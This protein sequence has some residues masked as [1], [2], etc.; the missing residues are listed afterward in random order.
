MTSAAQFAD[1]IELRLDCLTESDFSEI[2]LKLAALSQDSL[3]PIIYTLRPAE[4]GG[5]LNLD[6]ETRLR[7]WSSALPLLLR[8]NQNYADIELD[9]LHA[10]AQ[11]D[12]FAPDWNRIICSHHDFAG[13]PEGLEKIYERMAATRARIVKI[14]VQAN[15]ITDC[16]PALGLLQRARAEGREMIA[17]AMGEAGILTRILGPARGSFLTYGALDAEQATAPGQLLAADLRD[18]Y[19]IHEL[20][21]QTQIL[22]LVGQP[23]MHSVSP[24]IHNAAFA[25]CQLNAVYLPLEVSNLKNFM[26]RMVQP[27]TRELD[28]KLRGLSVTAPHKRAVMEYLDWLEPSAQ[29]I[30]AVNTIVIEDEKIFG[31]NTDARAALAPLR[32]VLKLNGARVAVIGAGGAARALL[33][34]LREACARVTVFARKAESAQETAQA[35]DAEFATLKDASFKEFEIVVNA[36]PLGTRGPEADETAAVASQLRGTKIAYD[37]VYNPSETRFLREAQ[38]AGCHTIGGLP[39]LV[40]Q[41]AA[42]FELWTDTAAPLAVMQQAA[43]KAVMSDE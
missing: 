29:A 17:I 8:D 28:W 43:L 9:L 36:T 42:Q 10:L 38:E 26:H 20:N 1:L 25:A 15:D 14:A 27:R 35:F 18:L 6:W 33:W 12:D 24:H 22:G 19:R 30:G 32:D 7:F 41:A 16:L 13:V 11:A 21:E 40:A 31:Y 5:R 2:H 3:P 34:S 23:V 4:Q 39:M 37:L